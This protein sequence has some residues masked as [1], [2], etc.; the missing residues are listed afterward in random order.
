M[1]PTWIGQHC[2]WVVV[3][4]L[5]RKAFRSKGLSMTGWCVKD[6][7]CGG[8]RRRKTEK[9]GMQET[10]ED[11]V[12]RV[13]S[14]PFW[15]GRPC[16]CLRLATTTS[17]RPARRGPNHLNN[18]CKS[19]ILLSLLRITLLLLSLV[20]EFSPNKIVC[21]SLWIPCL[22]CQQYVN[23]PPTTNIL[24]KSPH[25]PPPPICKFSRNTIVCKSSHILCFHCHRYMNFPMT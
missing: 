1:Q 6:W 8:W 18:F 21:K 20:C 13:A 23:N 24:C 9:E 7:I 12:V 22:H 14:A 2:V 10:R 11:Y 25:I 16:G 15:H 4:L 17:W 19:T 3:N 5:S